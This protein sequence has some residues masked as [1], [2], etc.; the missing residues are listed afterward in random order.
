VNIERLE[1]KYLCENLN[2]ANIVSSWIYNEFIKDIRDDL[3]VK[4][5]SSRIIKC[6]KDALP[7][8][9]VAV[10]DGRCVGTV[11]LVENDLKCRAYTPWL[12]ALIVDKNFRGKGIGKRLISFVQEIARQMGYKELYL[13]TEHASE[14]Y[15]KLGWQFVETCADS[16]GLEP[17][18]FKC[19]L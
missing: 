8:R 2:H 3:T 12:A 7:I 9:L 14:Y 18:V 11:S 19:V 13:R 4:E 5:I 17:D 15:K 10:L 16:Y 1:I 6:G